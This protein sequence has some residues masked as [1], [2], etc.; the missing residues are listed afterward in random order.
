MDYVCETNKI[1]QAGGEKRRRR[2]WNP[3]TDSKLTQLR[4]CFLNPLVSRNS[5]IQKC[6]S[7]REEHKGWT[8]VTEAKERKA[9]RPGEGKGETLLLAPGT[10][11]LK[12]FKA[13]KVTKHQC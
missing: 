11:L 1:I 9:K 6:Q 12:T 13:L 7:P 3:W 2:V 8:T 10:F 4:V 5:V